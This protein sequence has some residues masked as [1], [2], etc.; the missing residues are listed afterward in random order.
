MS[1]VESEIQFQDI[2]ARFAEEAELAMDGVRLNQRTKFRFG[3]G[4]RF[5]D[6]RDLKVGGF[7][8]NVRIEARGRSC[9]EI[10]RNGRVRVFGVKSGCIRFDAVCQRVIGRA[11]IGTAG[12]DRVIAGASGGGPR[13]EVNGRDERL[14][15]QF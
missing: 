6:A 15:D 13:M 12:G 14:A 8:R 5:G 2:N 7:G 3:D 4:A 10:G 1:D 9:K 11:K